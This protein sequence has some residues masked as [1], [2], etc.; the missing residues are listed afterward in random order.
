MAGLTNSGFVPET[1]L[2][3]T[4]RIQGK[5]EAFSP[6]F[7]FS[8]ES[9]DGQLVSIMSYELYTAWTQLDLVYNSYNPN[10]A[11]GAALRNLGLITGIPYGAAQRSTAT[12]EL[13]GVSGTIVPRNSLVSDNDGNL[14]HV[15]FDTTIPS[16]AQVMSEVAGALPVVS[17]SL[18]TIVTALVGWTGITQTTNGTLGS[19]A[20]TSTQ[21]RNLR[22]ATVVRNYTSVVDTLT[23]RVVELGIEQVSVVNNDDPAVT[24]PDGTPPN[25]IHVTIGEVGSVTDADIAQVILN[26]KPLG[27]PTYLH[28]TTG[29]SE[30][31]LDSQGVS[32][33][34]NFSKAVEV[35]IDISVNITYL[36][37][38]NA[39][40]ETEIKNALVA[41]INSLL[42]GEDVIWSR[43]FSLV[44][45]YGKAQINSL[46]V[47][48]VGGSLTAGNVVLTDGEF[49]SQSLVDV[50]V[51]VV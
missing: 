5:L 36:S 48:R 4:S 28:P 32:H 41:H 22:Q 18:T 1:L 51:V 12:I 17:G 16:N 45:P 23:A 39:G 25:T 35:P 31:V 7:D 37:L 46:T 11:T 50:E 44:T 38:D 47:G 13:Q 6:G 10:A 43:L 49:A 19:K 21:Y 14:F 9:P 2:N 3:I 42:A 33:T 34:I 8:P 30:T 27:C 26:T 20:Q 40:A 24:H 15:V 29:V